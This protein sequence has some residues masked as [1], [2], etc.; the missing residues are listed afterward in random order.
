MRNQIDP[1]ETGTIETTFIRAGVPAI[2]LEIGSPKRWQ[3]ELI[4][5]SV[6]FIFRAL[7]EWGITDVDVADVDPSITYA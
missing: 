3:P 7:N 1:G 5:R 2:T 6:D 4:S